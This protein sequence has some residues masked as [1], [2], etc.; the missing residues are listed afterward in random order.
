MDTEQMSG[1]SARRLLESV[2]PD[3]C[4]AYRSLGRVLTKSDWTFSRVIS[5]DPAGGGARP[6]SRFINARVLFSHMQPGKAGGPQRLSTC[7]LAR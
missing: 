5:R 7:W 3:G 6:L 4:L 1:T 2:E